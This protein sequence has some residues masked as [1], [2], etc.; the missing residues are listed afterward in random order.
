MVWKSRSNDVPHRSP[1]PTDRIEPVAHQP[2]VATR[3]D[4]ATVLGEERSLGDR[5]QA[6]KQGQPFVEDVAHDVTVA[7]G[8]EELQG[9]QR[10]HGTG[11]GD[12]VRSG[13]AAARQD[14]VQVGR[15]QVG[16]EQ[17]QSAELGVERARCQVELADIGD[18]GGDG[19]G[20]IG[21]LLVAASR[22]FGE[23][24]FLEDR[25]DRRRAERLAVAGQGAADVVDGEVLLPQGDDLLRE[26]VSACPAVGP[27]VRWGRRSRG[28][29]DCGTDGR[30]RESCRGC[31]RTAG[32][33]R[34]RR[35]R[36]RRR[37]AGLRTVG[38]WSSRVPRT[39]VP[40]LGGLWN[41][42]P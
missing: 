34:R 29:G 37:P 12:H 3:R 41:Y 8:A 7:C 31:S 15:D 20:L 26:A 11:G 27:G 24:L 6:G 36:R 28:R 4:A 39:G 2:R 32:P 10:S 40:V 19:T 9:Q 1:R 23:A 13:E 30:G 33:P 35:G 22:Q 17:E 14:P 42:R 18:I 38:G 16:Q 5:V 21:S 25:G